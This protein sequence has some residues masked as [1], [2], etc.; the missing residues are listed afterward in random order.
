[1][2]DI[3]VNIYKVYVIFHDE[4]V[5]DHRSRVVSMWWAPRAST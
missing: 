3:D 4:E 1:M 5:Q 2:T